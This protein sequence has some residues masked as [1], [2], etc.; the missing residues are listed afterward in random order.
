M[1][2]MFIKCLNVS[3][4][5]HI[6]DAFAPMYVEKMFLKNALKVHEL[7]LFSKYKKLL[8]D[9]SMSYIMLTCVPLWLYANVVSV[10]APKLFVICL[11]ESGLDCCFYLNHHENRFLSGSASQSCYRH[12]VGNNHINSIAA[13]KKS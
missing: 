10:I 13:G 11:K 7:F 3:H 4:I 1:W 6:T 8:P 9:L 2:L 5:D 12:T